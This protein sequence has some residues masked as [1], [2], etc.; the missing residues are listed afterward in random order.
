MEG[1]LAR[2]QDLGLVDRQRM[3]QDQRRVQV[4]LTEQ[5]QS[6]VDQLTPLSEETYR[7]LEAELGRDFIAKLYSQL[8]RLLDVLG[9]G[10]PVDS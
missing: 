7:E 2:M 9:P 10:E 8:D 5:G 1:I 4:S 6:L 3:E